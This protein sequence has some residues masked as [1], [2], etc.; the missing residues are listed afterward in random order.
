MADEEALRRG[1]VE[2]DAVAAELLG[3]FV[4]HYARVQSARPQAEA[5]ARAEVF[6][7]WVVRK[8]ANLQIMLLG[9]AEQVE[10]LNR[11]LHHPPTEG[12]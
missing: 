2:V 1:L 4:R 8:L 7:G 9:L 12:G 3:E 10:E 11:R 5:A 6:E